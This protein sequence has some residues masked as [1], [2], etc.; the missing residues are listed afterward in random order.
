MSW[1]KKLAEILAPCPA[2]VI[3]VRQ[4][5]KEKYYNNKYPKKDMTYYG[6]VVPKTKNRVKIDV[7]AKAVSR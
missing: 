2:P 7:D 4:H 1:L 6:R 5:P 3:N